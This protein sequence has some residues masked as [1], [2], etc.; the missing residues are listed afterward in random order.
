MRLHMCRGNGHG[1]V[2]PCCFPCYCSL[3]TVPACENMYIHVEGRAPRAAPRLHTH[4]RMKFAGVLTP[5][6]LSAADRNA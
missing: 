3:S 2:R 6:S 4:A 1:L 5:R